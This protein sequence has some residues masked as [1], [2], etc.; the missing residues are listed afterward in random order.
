MASFM[1]ALILRARDK[2]AKGIKDGA[3]IHKIKKP[4][5]RI[6]CNRDGT[7]QKFYS[8]AACRRQETTLM[9][10]HILLLEDNLR[11]R[12]LLEKTLI[13]EGLVCQITHARSKA[14]FQAA[15]EQAEYDFD[16]LGFTSRVTAELPHSPPAGNSAG[17]T[18]H[19]CRRI[20][21]AKNSCGK[22]EIR[23][24]RILFLK[25]LNRLGRPY[26]GA[27]REAHERKDTGSGRKSGCGFNPAPWKPLP[28]A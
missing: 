11:D 27:L 25:R 12:Q 24:P 7:K 19:F 16:H 9:S 10:M 8:S 17:H 26:T 22:P 20:H 13:N 4:M 5:A 21:R 3:G 2:R 1:P 23:R 14:E 6:P 15:L 18:I 28:M